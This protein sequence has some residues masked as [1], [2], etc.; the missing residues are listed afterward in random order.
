MQKQEVIWMSVSKRL[1]RLMNEALVIPFNSSSK[2]VLMS[3]CH[4]GIGT[5]NDNFLRNQNLFFAALEYYYEKGF[6]YIELGDGDELWENRD[7]NSIISTHVNTF[8]L[9]SKFYKENRLFMIYGN[10]DMCKK[11]NSYIRKKYSTYFNEHDQCEKPLFPGIYIPEGILLKD[12]LGNNNILLAHGHQGDLFNDTLW[13]MSRFLVRYL[14]RPL[15][16]IGINDPTSAAKNYTKKDSAEKKL[17]KWS[18]KE[19]Q[20]LICGHTHRSV[21]PQPGESLYF[22]DGSCIHPRCITAIEISNYEIILVKWTVQTKHDRSLFVGREVLKG[23]IS[24]NSFTSPYLC[25]H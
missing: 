6:S 17:Q 12:T 20:M 25:S 22:N 24:L 15:E 4:R 8:W 23:P 13:K 11:N 14:W 21:F 5:W 2:L 16:L 7:L 10:H 1:S 3:D 9:M 19:N 18:S